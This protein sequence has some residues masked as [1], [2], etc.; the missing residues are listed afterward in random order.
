MRQ[1]DDITEAI[2]EAAI[3]IHRDLGPGFLESVSEAVV[4]T[5]TGRPIRVR[6]T[7]VRRRLPS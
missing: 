7:G 4:A 2:I 5:T 3:Q 6:R 1:L